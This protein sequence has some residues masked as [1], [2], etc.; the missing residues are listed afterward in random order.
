MKITQDEVVDS[1]TTLHIVLEDA[2]LD[3]YL[4]RGYRQVSNRVVIPGFRPG[5][6]PR[7]IVEGFMGRESL[8]TEVLDNM[9]YEV[10]DRAVKEQELDAVGVPRID[11][12]ELDPVQF[13]AT[14][15]LKPEVQLGDY[16]STRIEFEQADVDADAVTE[17]LDNI[18]ESLG[19]WETVDRAPQFSDLAT[20]DL[21]GTVEDEETWNREDTAFYLDE[22]G[23][24]PIPGFAEKLV[25]A[26]LGQEFTFDLVVP[27]DHRDASI[28]GKEASFTVTVKDVKQRDLPELNDEFAQ[29][30]PDGFAD[31]AALR[32]AV[33]DAIRQNSEQEAEQQYQTRVID[34][35]LEAATIDLP[36][37]LLEREADHIEG[38][39]DRFL[40]QANIRRDD[41]L[42]SIGKTEEEVRQE[43]EE[44]AEQRLRRNFAI[45]Q[46]TEV[47]GIEVTEPDIDERF[48]QMFAGQPL[49]R[50][51]RRERRESVERMLKYEKTV[52]LLV[53]IAKSEV[54][55]DGDDVDSE[56]N[57]TEVSDQTGEH[58]DS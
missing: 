37:V 17:R 26:E 1:Q 47:E 38:D 3:P 4:D 50:Q 6:A 35:L 53:T 42:R 49:R 27:E 16:H 31:L 32:T 44:E 41:F 30:L 33:E 55:P 21:R 36:P 9:V 15:A 39:Q 14:V 25:G 10:A 24:N 5:K 13:T 51:E 58:D 52:E 8:L 46:V 54:A 57:N 45:G 2:D 43:A 12:L 40:E 22:E 11:D 23:N 20:I 7:R 28:S 56:N 48:N 18:R 29:G 19:T 34:A